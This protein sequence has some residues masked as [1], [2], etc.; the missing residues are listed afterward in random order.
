MS[1]EVTRGE[2]RGRVRVGL[3]DDNRGGGGAVRLIFLKSRQP[4]DR[5]QKAKGPAMSAC[6]VEGQGG[7]GGEGG[8]K[9]REVLN[10]N[11]QCTWTFVP[12]STLLVCGHASQQAAL[13]LQTSR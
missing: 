5:L 4:D 11:K 1:E 10:E 8:G 13:G 12:L 7:G 9:F 2:R 3:E 6:L